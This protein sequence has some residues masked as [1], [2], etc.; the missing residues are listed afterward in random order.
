[1]TYGKEVTFP[2]TIVE[3]P[4]LVVTGLR[5]YEKWSGGLRTIGEVWHPQP[6]RDLG[7][8][9]KT[10]EKFDETKGWEKME[11]VKDRLAEVRVIVASQPRLAKTGKK[12]P[13]LF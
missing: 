1:L 3:T 7:R 8:A 6:H 9:I 11:A 13:D 10:P 4:P 5:F 12:E 2:A